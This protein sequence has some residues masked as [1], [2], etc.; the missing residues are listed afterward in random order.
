MAYVKQPRTWNKFNATDAISTLHEIMSASYS[1]IDS[2]TS[3]KL[4]DVILEFETFMDDVK[5][6]VQIMDNKVPV[7]KKVKAGS[8]KAGRRIQ[9]SMILSEILREKLDVNNCANYKYPFVKSIAQ[10]SLTSKHN[11]DKIENIFSE[12]WDLDIPDCV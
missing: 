1:S 2:S 3:I 11:N 8:Q 10:D 9:D 12:K 7:A 6:A 4:P 5:E